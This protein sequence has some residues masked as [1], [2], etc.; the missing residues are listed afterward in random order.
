MKN[1]STILRWPIWFLEIFTE[2]KS[3]EANPILGNYVLNRCGLHVVR[4]VLAHS[5]T[6]IRRFILSFSMT[7]EERSQFRRQGFLVKEQMLQPELYRALSAEAEA[8][9]PEIR[10]FVQGDT[11]TEFVFLDSVKRE[12]LPAAANVYQQKSV[13]RLLNYVAACALNPWMDFLRVVNRGGRAEMDPQKQFHSDTF[14]PTMKAWLFLHPVTDY[15]GPFEYI[16]GS[17]RLTW[18]RICWEYRMSVDVRSESETYARRGSLRVT[19]ADLQ[20]LGYGPVKRFTVAGNTLVVAD[21]FGFHR[22]GEGGAQSQRLSLAYSNR[23]NPFL[24]IPIPA[25]PVFDRL[26]ERIVNHHHR[27]SSLLREPES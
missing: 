13:N 9:W 27:G 3:F 22:R 12:R 23:I 8:S 19:E 25:W 16:E 24:P 5:L 10:E 20:Y 26:A 2:A 6:G 7:R 11:T 15:E 21:T 14:H 4:L 18:K 1:V 17:H